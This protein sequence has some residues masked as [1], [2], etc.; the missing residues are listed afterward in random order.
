MRSEN[1]MNS[2]Y[3]HYQYGGQIIITISPF[4]NLI[5]TRLHFTSLL[6]GVVHMKFGV[7]KIQL[8]IFNMLKHFLMISDAICI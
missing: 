8:Y 7:I 4:D 5:R 6:S 3:Y 2:Y 1:G